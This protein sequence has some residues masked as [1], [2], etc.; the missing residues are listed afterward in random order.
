M[1]FL[2]DA[3]VDTVGH[4]KYSYGPQSAPWPTWAGRRRPAHTRVS[5]LPDGVRH[6]CE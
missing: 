6:G 5:A 4:P 3:P 2:A 1:V